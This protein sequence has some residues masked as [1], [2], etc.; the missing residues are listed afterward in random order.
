MIKR[1]LVVEDRKDIADELVKWISRIEM[2][3]E[4]E[5]AVDQALTKNEALQKLRFKTYHVAMLDIMLTDSQHDEG[6]LEVQSE[7]VKSKE[8]TQC[9][10]MSATDNHLVPIKAFRGGILD[11]FD[12]SR[13]M[14]NPELWTERVKEGLYTSR[15][16]IY[17][18]QHDLLHFLSLPDRPSPFWDHNVKDRLRCNVIDLP[19]IFDVVFSKYLPLLPVKGEPKVITLSKEG[20]YGEF[21]SKALGFPVHIALY[22]AESS[23]VKPADSYSVEKIYER[24]KGAVYAVVWKIKE[25]SVRENFD[26][27]IWDRKYQRN[28]EEE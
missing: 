7:I 3:G 26:E 28:L 15:I 19:H 2:N 1:V 25:G 5:I 18:S 11:Y 4:D 17:G 16:P 6:G 20:V 23:P 13:D 27:S 14:A 10:I 9:I 21:W 12:K 22:S 8:G 24:T